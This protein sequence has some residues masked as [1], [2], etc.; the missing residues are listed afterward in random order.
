[1]EKALGPEANLEIK[2]VE[3]KLRLALKYDGKQLDGELAI[4]LDSDLLVDKLADLIPG[5]SA[6]E[7]GALAALKLG[8]KAA[9]GKV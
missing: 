7:Q 2:G 8:L 6:L 1:M 5:D 3:G 4:S 9:L